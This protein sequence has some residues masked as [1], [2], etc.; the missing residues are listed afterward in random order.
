[1][2]PDHQVPNRN[3]YY[4]LDFTL[5]HQNRYICDAEGKVQCLTGWKER[6][7]NPDPDYPCSEAIC[8]P[9]C[10]HGLCN[11]PGVCACDVGW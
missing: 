5:Q 8:S 1:M 7:Y 6:D 9:E 3:A 11:L 10:V 4:V 2:F